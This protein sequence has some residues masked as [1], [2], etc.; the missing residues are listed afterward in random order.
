M[1]KN[2]ASGL[3]QNRFQGFEFKPGGTAEA[4]FLRE[5]VVFNI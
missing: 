3:H 1:L 5:F 2:K 4:C